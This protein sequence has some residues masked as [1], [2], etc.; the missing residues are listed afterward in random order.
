MPYFLTL[1]RQ[2]AFA[3]K[4]DAKKIVVLVGFFSI[5]NN[6]VR[7]LTILHLIC[8]LNELFGYYFR[9]MLFCGLRCSCSFAPKNK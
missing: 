8:N 7:A 5:K 1:N 2:A 4:N 6:G 3:F 9:G